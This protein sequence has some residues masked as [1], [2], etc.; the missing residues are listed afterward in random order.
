[1]SQKVKRI[2]ALL[3]SISLALLS[4]FMSVSADNQPS[5]SRIETVYGYTYS[6]ISRIHN[7]TSGAIG[8]Q[9]TVYVESANTVP[10]GYM[11]AKAR[12]YDDDGNLVT[13]TGWSYNTYPAASE[14]Q[15]ATYYVSSG[16]YYSRGRVKLYNGN[17]Y[18]EFDAYIS[19]VMQPLRTGISIQRN[20]NG[21]LYGSE[22]LLSEFGI[23]LDLISAKNSQGIVGYVRASDLYN[24]EVYTP[25]DAIAAMSIERANSIPMYLSDGITMIGTFEVTN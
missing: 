19:P 3:L 14:L 22:L 5:D 16:E 25:E 4:M 11:A 24:D 10:T 18:T 7:E 12:L 9:T 21:E 6:F 15:S 8:Y 1:M 20:Q 23:Q 13:Y 2:I 17:G